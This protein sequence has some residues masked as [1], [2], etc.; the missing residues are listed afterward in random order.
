MI[1][2][3]QRNPRPFLLN[4]KTELITLLVVCLC[5]FLAIAFPHKDGVQLF[6]CI[7][8]F[9]IGLPILFIRLILKKTLA[10][11]GLNIAQKKSGFLWAGLMLMLS[12]LITFVLVYFFQLNTRYIL[13]VFIV[14]NFWIFLFY[15]MVL[16]NGILFILEFFFHGFIQTALERKLGAWSILIQ[17]VIFMGFFFFIQKLSWQYTPFIILSLTGGV[18]AYKSKS[19]IYSYLMGLAFLLCFDVYIIGL[20]K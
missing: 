18:V 3:T 14:H 2:K 20:V 15:E 13:P 11:F 5:L 10:E 12:F 16:M 19:F 9:L 17:F 7:I 4:W 8:F 6:S 1:S